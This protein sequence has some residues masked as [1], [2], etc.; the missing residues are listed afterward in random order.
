MQFDSSVAYPHLCRAGQFHQPLLAP[1]RQRSKKTKIPEK[2]LSA[3]A[4]AQCWK[5]SCLFCAAVQFSISA[6]FSPFSNSSWRAR[7]AQGQKM[8]KRSENHPI[9][10]KWKFVW[11]HWK[12]PDLC[13]KEISQAG[14]VLNSGLE[15]VLELNLGDHTVFRYRN[16]PQVRDTYI[17]TF[18]KFWWSPQVLLN[19]KLQSSTCNSNRTNLLFLSSGRSRIRM[20]I[21]IPRGLIGAIRD[22]VGV[23]VQL[24]VAQLTRY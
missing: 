4:L 24:E 20:S 16:L 10:M 21:P 19:I 6:P 23:I 12:S 18:C 11:N 9:C 1:P 2:N 14:D 8:E 5:H 7:G 13:A 22:K 3:S 15:S 17:S